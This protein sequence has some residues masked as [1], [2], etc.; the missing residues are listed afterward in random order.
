M[1]WELELFF[2]FYTL[3]IWGGAY[4]PNAP[5]AYRPALAA[6]AVSAAATGYSHRQH[7]PDSRIDVRKNT[8]QRDRQTPGRRDVNE[9]SWA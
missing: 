3:H 7:P 2:V 8:A 6:V 1:H 4:A 9:A 5:P